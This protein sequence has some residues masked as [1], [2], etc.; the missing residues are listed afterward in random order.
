MKKIK[1]LKIMSFLFL[2]LSLFSTITCFAAGHYYGAYFIAGKNQYVIKECEEDDEKADFIL[3]FTYNP[4]N[5]QDKFF[6][7]KLKRFEVSINKRYQKFGRYNE[8][9]IW[10][11][12]FGSSIGRLP[13]IKGYEKHHIIS[14]CVLKSC[15]FKD[16]SHAPAVI[17]SKKS[18]SKTSSYRKKLNSSYLSDELKTYKEEGKGKAFSKGALDL[19]ENI[20]GIGGTSILRPDGYTIL[21]EEDI[22]CTKVDLKDL[23]EEEQTMIIEDLEY[24][25][26]DINDLVLVKEEEPLQEEHN[27][28]ESCVIKDESNRMEEE[29]IENEENLQRKE[30]QN[31]KGI[32]DSTM[33]ED[34]IYISAI[35]Y[36][37]SIIDG[38][39]TK[40]EGNSTL[41]NPELT[42]IL[43]DV[44]ELKDK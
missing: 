12:M 28:K 27:K 32:D 42:Y 15:G 1:V 20:S 14:N 4:E 36:E 34:P 22:S 40:F 17:L 21:Q 43:P 7:K 29:P 18:H 30:K 38:A 26:N 41:E 16:K 37:P 3:K 19:K 39:S 33:E 2:L 35:K 25:P 10:P 44:L 24:S 9:N 31:D 5:E 13:S 11:F 6:E 8:D 23:P